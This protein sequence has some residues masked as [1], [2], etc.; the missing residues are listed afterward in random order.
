MT[1]TNDARGPLFLLTFLSSFAGLAFEIALTRFF[2]ITLSYHF[3]FMVLSIAMLGIGA[4][5]TLLSRRPR[6]RRAGLVPAYGLLFAATIPLASVTANM[7]PFDPARLSWDSMQLLLLALYYLVLAVPFFCFGLIIASMYTLFPG[8]SGLVYS[9]DLLGAGCGAVALFALLAMGGPE[10]VPCVASSLVAASLLLFRD[11]RVRVTAVLLLCA[12]L[13]VLS[14]RPAVIQPKISPYKPLALA[15]RFPG[16]NHLFTAYSPSSRIDAFTSP[17]VRFAPGLS[18]RYLEPLPHQTGIAID[19]GEMDAYTDDRNSDR[20]AFVRHL[21]S[22]LPYLLTQNNDVLILDPRGGLPVLTARQHGA[23]NLSAVESN[24]LL[25]RAV[26]RL[27]AAS[28]GISVDVLEP[29][30]GRSW[31]GATGRLF[32]VIDISSLGTL[33]SGSFGFSEDYRFT[34]EAFREYLAHLKPAGFLAVNLYI[35]PPPRKELRVLSTIAEALREAV[36]GD[37][38]RQMAAIR[39]WD[40]MTIVVK[41]SPLTRKD[42]DVIRTFARNMRFDLMHYPGIGRQETNQYIRMPDDRYGDAVRQVID[43]A[44]RD[45]FLEQYLFDVGPAHDDKPFVHY[46]LRWRELERIYRVMGEKWHYFL[47]EGY[48]LPVL[49]VQALVLGAVLMVLPAGAGKREDPAPRVRGLP[50]VLAYF[51]ILGLGYLFIEVALIQKMILPLEDPTTAAGVVI[52]SILASS[53]VGS[54]L[55]Q[56]WE[57]LRR[58]STLVLLSGLT[59]AYSLALPEIIPSLLRLPSAARTAGAVLI[60]IPA[61]LLMG[62]PFPLGVSLLARFAP[63]LIPWAWA[64]NGCCSV[65]A[66]VLAVMIALTAGFDAVIRTGSFLYLLGSFTLSRIARQAAVPGSIPGQDHRFF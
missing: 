46:Y 52:A 21:P 41:R 54:L 45:R 35:I 3:A 34:V 59:L 65:L 1:G 43:P 38:S 14:L 44:T 8:R 24:P 16:A 20:L 10:N 62:V 12:N 37:L 17:V 9:A 11:R 25:L 64:V 29:G 40:T 56:R 60:V 6:L 63:G 4:S 31:L 53:G 28:G 57:G 30:L 51:A 47:E 26:R 58:P 39:S 13:L 18:L 7:I 36:D 48:L 2:S 32:D 55:S 42:I 19:A 23:R 15:M 33:P 66:P 5:G 50:V 27:S 49:F 61:G 22:A